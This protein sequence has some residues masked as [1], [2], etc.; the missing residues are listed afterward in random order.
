VKSIVLPE[1]K[2]GIETASMILRRILS[3]F[4]LEA[5]I[6][7]TRGAGQTGVSGEELSFCAWSKQ[8]I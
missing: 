5:E 7:P 2:S 1:P 4:G 6:L 8:I 3:H